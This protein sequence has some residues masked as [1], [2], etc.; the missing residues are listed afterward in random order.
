MGRTNDRAK[1]APAR[2]PDPPGRDASLNTDGRAAQI[3]IFRR[4]TPTEKLSAAAR[5]YWS[6]RRLKEAG[7]RAFHPDWSDEQIRKAVND[8]FL[9]RRD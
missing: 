1:G 4:M 2:S 8:A 9:Y 3:D 7:L 5:L 6:A